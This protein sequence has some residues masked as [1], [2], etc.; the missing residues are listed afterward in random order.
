MPS[1]FSLRVTSLHDEMQEV[2]TI[3]I[4]IGSV[5]SIEFEPLLDYLSTTVLN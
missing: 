5:L 4:V 3:R 2:S 1:V